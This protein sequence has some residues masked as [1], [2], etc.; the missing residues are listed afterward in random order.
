MVTS[1]ILDESKMTLLSE[2]KEIQ[3]SVEEVETPQS[4]VEEETTNEEVELK[5]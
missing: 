5:L 2:V 3:T 4:E 1:N